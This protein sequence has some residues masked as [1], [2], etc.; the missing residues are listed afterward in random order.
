MQIKR[1]IIQHNTWMKSKTVM[2][3]NTDKAVEQQELS[4]FLVGKEKW[5][6]TLE[7]SSAVSYKTKYTHAM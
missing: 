6:N 1:T 5:Y 4:F 7:N 2:T 3:M